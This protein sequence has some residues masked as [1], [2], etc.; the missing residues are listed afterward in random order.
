MKTSLRAKLMGA[1]VLAGGLLLLLS[2]AVIWSLGY[3]HRVD[4]H[5]AIY[6][7]EAEH[8]GRY[9][10]L[11]VESDIRNLNSLLAVG[12]VPALLQ[13][14]EQLPDSDV[15]PDRV[16]EIDKSWPSLSP[17]SPEVAHALDNR[18]AAQLRAFKR[19]N[20]LFVEILVA[21]EK[22]R[23]VAA[24][25]KTSDYDQ[26]DEAWWQKGMTLHRGQALVEG[27]GI[28]ESA[29]VF[30]LDISLPVI[31]EGQ[32]EPS[33]VLKAV[34]N[35]SPLFASVPIL[36]PDPDA[37]AEIVEPNGHVLI[38]LADPKF[39]PGQETLPADLVRQMKKKHLG[40]KISA[41]EGGEA[42]MVGFA[43][44]HL[45]GMYSADSPIV[46]RPLYVVVRQPAATLL[47]P[48]RQRAAFLMLA[49]SLV[50]L[51][52]AAAG[53]FFSGRN[54]LQPIE[55]LRKAAAAVAATTSPSQK[56]ETGGARPSSEDQAKA[57]LR[58]VAAVRTGDEME[59]MAT[60][61]SVMAARLLR[62]QSDLKT[63]IAAKTA[64]IQRDLE[65]A[66]D[67]QRAFLPRTY[68]RV[69]TRA[70]QGGLT[71]NFHHVYQAA[72]SVSGD[73][74]DVVKLSDHCA[75][76]LIADVMGH[77]TR[78][79]L[80]TAIL[81]TLLH[82][83]TKTSNDPAVFLSSLN[84]H[85]Y[86]T[87]KQTDQLIF[88]SACFLVL[89]TGEQTVRCASA[90]HPSPLV[91]NRVSGRVESLF[92]AL[93]GNPALGLLPDSFYTVFK[94]ALS[95]EDVFLLFT[96]GV[97]EALSERDEEF[98]VERLRRSVELHL[99]E[100]LGLLTQDIL[101]SV[102]DFT[103]HAPLSDDLCLV[104]VEAVPENAGHSAGGAPGG[105]GSKHSG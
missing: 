86:E 68:P 71:L 91:G 38:R 102:L 41:M 53:I 84:H 36:S 99:D 72:M 92:T 29:K 51:G 18:L 40:W 44:V 37:S 83:L 14:I 43:P 3:R 28:D 76:I 20:W 96:D 87:M 104:A 39:V 24:T 23:L 16:A 25:G 94:R 73:F 34:V 50:I 4:E 61:F 57:A 47:A 97:V 26:S 66:R 77:G 60:D 56:E 98:G 90:G 74:F 58:E 95:A 67:F 79:A 7:G 48:L 88:V 93:K 45:L 9:L 85:F 103:D 1:F 52:A 69:P 81:R 30:S 10:S 19:L 62:Y 101:E 59:E 55:A 65:M 12:G 15:P 80:V 100:S 33:G 46:G 22:G 54:I 70:G 27:F 82:G 63:E 13:Q 31:L 35:A 49:G 75:G 105:A 64:E 21:D 8:V 11:L 89:D 5:G 78:S 2:L 17:Q 42:E 32:S 6:R